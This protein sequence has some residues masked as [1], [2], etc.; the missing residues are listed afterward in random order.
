M[1][2]VQ[3]DIHW[4]DDSTWEFVAYAARRVAD[5][6]LVLAVTYR[7]EEIG[8]AH[9]WW[10]ALVRLK[11]EPSVLSLPLPW[12]SAADGER[13]VRAIDPALPQATVA[14]IVERGAGTP[15]LVEELASLASGPGE[16]LLVPDIVRATMRERAACTCTGVIWMRPASCSKGRTQQAMPAPAA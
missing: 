12:L 2:W 10:P 5:L 3:D 7:E 16:L 13:I 14:K 1:L 11:R 8:P 4:A 9:P 6:A 15:L